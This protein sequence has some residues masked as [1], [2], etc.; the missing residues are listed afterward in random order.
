MLKV[1]EGKQTCGTL[2]PPAAGVIRAL[3]GSFTAAGRCRSAREALQQFITG[4][5]KF[6]TRIYW[7]LPQGRSAAKNE[8]VV[9]F[10]AGHSHHGEVIAA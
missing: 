2:W 9:D 4:P 7:M 5:F 3:G 6:N 1:P 8:T 10:H